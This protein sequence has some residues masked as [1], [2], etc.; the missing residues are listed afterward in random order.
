LSSAK[1]RSQT[2]LLTFL[3]QGLSSLT[4][5][6][7]SA[8]AAGLLTARDFGAFAVATT[9]LVLVVGIARSW[10]GNSLMI[11]SPA[12]DQSTYERML[13]GAFMLSGLIGI[14][15]SALVMTGAFLADG[16]L[17]AA[18]LTLALCIPVVTTQDALRLGALARRNPRLAC[19]NDAA[20]LIAAVLALMALRRTDTMSV[21]LAVVAAI[22]TA[23]AGLVVGLSLEPTAATRGRTRE[24]FAN[25]NA[26]GARMSADFLIALT[27]SAAPLVLITAWRA[28]LAAAGFLRTAVILLGPLSVVYAGSTLYMQPRMSVVRANSA[29]VRNLARSQS[30]WNSVVAAAWLGVALAIPD[31][32]GIRIFGAS[33]S[34]ST[35]Y[36]A[37][38]GV[39][40]IAMAVP[41]GPLTAL[42][43][44]GRLNANLAAQVITALTVL[45]STAV[46]GLLTHDGMIRGFAVGH[47]LSMFIAWMI[48]LRVPSRLGASE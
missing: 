14:V 20:W 24:W 9:V 26:T 15:A 18:L 28:D 10:A 37:N 11:L 48:L 7:G 25:S 35:D 19:W 1:R 39:A 45:T 36:V 23:A 30:F 27:Y 3:D 6:G 44:S 8:L 47:L 29:H 32:V 42:R 41:T 16:S 4:N 22:G 12:V 17:R 46:G 34:G 43:S 33:W 40:F 21:T 38:L 2:R 5:F 13:S 31:R